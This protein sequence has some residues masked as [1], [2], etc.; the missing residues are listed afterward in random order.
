MV[1]GQLTEREQHIIHQLLAEKG[2]LTYEIREVVNEGQFLPG[3]NYPLEIELLSGEVITPT[4][5]YDFWLDWQ[6]Q[7]Y[8]L[9]PWHEIDIDNSREKEE[10]RQV[11]KRLK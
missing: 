9:E 4:S 5:A 1:G 6:G 8:V 2:I 3:G 10:I 11:Q 7:H